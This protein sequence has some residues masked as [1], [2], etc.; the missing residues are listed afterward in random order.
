[1]NPFELKRKPL[2]ELAELSAQTSAIRD[3]IKESR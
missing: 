2:E 1:M 3:L